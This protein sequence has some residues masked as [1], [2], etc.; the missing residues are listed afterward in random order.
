MSRSRSASSPV[1]ERVDPA[2]ARPHRVRL[3]E[4]SGVLVDLPERL[5]SDASVWRSPE[6]PRIPIDANVEIGYRDAREEVGDRAHLAAV[7]SATGVAVQ[8]TG[9]SGGPPTRSRRRP[10]LGDQ[11]RGQHE[12]SD[13]VAAQPRPAIGREHPGTGQPS[14]QRHQRSAKLARGPSLSLTRSRFSKRNR[15]FTAVRSPSARSAGR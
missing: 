4:E 6:E 5:V 12:T 15:P 7:I 11:E 3:D 1:T 2:R 13:Y 10:S 8:A 14:R 9:M